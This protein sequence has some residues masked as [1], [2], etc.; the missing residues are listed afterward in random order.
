[1]D[2]IT[3]TA[4]ELQVLV[5]SSAVALL[6]QLRAAGLPGHRFLS[7]STHEH[8]AWPSSSAAWMCSSAWICRHT[9]W[10]RGERL[11]QITEI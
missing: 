7:L 9:D 5:S 1:M 11:P 4:S 2:L 6:L 8:K 10:P 3:N